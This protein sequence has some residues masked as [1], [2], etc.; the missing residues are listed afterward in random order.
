[1]DIGVF[2][3]LILVYKNVEFKLITVLR[4]N[5]SH[6]ICPPPPLGVTGTKGGRGGEDIT[7]RDKINGTGTHIFLLN[8]PYCMY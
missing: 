7:V 5:L 4:K 2:S 1:V 3:E 6:I 8:F